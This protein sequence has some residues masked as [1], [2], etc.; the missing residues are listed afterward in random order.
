MPV[1]AFDPL[2]GSGGGS[3]YRDLH[4]DWIT[5]EALQ[6]GTK[7]VV[8]TYP[9]KQVDV[10]LLSPIGGGIQEYDADFVVTGN[11]LSWSGKPIESVLEIGDKLFILYEK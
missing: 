1:T 7:S 9:P 2:A 8:L 11:V 6:I 10:I 3:A 4:V 5:L